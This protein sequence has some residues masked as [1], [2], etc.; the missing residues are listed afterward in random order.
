M[1]NDFSLQ[2]NETQGLMNKDL[3]YDK[4]LNPFNRTKFKSNENQMK[5]LSELIERE[6]P[7]KEEETFTQTKEKDTVLMVTEGRSNKTIFKT[8]NNALPK[9]NIHLLAKEILT[10]CNVFHKKNIHNNTSLIT[11]KGKLMITKGMSVKDFQNRYH[12]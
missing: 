1:I 10:R 3:Q 12:L 6:S 2:I 8:D 5:I 11:N 4:N 9:E 7:I